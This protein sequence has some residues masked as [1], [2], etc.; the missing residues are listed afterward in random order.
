MLSG[1]P[2]PKVRAVGRTR[3]ACR[4]PL[5]GRNGYRGKVGRYAARRA[6]AFASHEHDNGRQCNICPEGKAAM[7]AHGVPPV[8]AF[9]FHRSAQRFTAGAENRSSIKVSSTDDGQCA[10]HDEPA[11]ALRRSLTA[12]PVRMLA[13]TNASLYRV[14]INGVTQTNSCEDHRPK[15]RREFRE[16]FRTWRRQRNSQDAFLPSSSS[17]R[18]ANGE[19]VA[20]LPPPRV[21]LL[22]PF[23]SSCRWCSLSWQ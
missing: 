16:R 13:A 11:L 1:V 23:A 10:S 9:V 20:T 21:L 8:G 6:D 15:C 3:H 19:W 5:S 17:L 7:I 2:A 18:F 14:C 22:S 4:L 12:S